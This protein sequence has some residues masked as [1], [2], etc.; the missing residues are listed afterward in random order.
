MPQLPLLLSNPRRNPRR[1]VRQVSV[2]VQVRTM[3]RTRWRLWIPMSTGQ[4]ISRLTRIP[5]SRVSRVD[6]ARSQGGISL[7]SI[8]GAAISVDGQD[9]RYGDVTEEDQERMSSDEYLVSSYM[10][11]T[12]PRRVVDLMVTLDR[13]IIGSPKNWHSSRTPRISKSA[14]RVESF[15]HLGDINLSL[16]SHHRIVT[17]S[18][19][20]NPTHR[21][22]VVPESYSLVLPHDI[23]PEFAL[24]HSYASLRLGA[25]EGHLVPR[26]A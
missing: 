23:A 3:A 2:R 11:K 25:Q 26:Y 6:R 20:M 7:T 18:R 9:M 19:C 4:R 5:S 21:S 13:T 17:A 16:K 15:Q 10:L 8:L 24:A 1:A 12:N 14:R 22:R